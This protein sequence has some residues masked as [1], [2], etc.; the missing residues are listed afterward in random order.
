MRGN[1]RFLHLKKKRVVVAITQQQN[2]IGTCTNATHADNP[3]SNIDNPVSG[4]H[5]PTLT[6][7]S[8]GIFHQ[9]FRYSFMGFRVNASEH[10]GIFIEFQ[11]SGKVSFFRRQ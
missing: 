7:E 9:G 2:E 10:R 3:M 1:D 11:D 5:E 8:V 4:K 6:R